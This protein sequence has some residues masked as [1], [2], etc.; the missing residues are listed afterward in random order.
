MAKFR[1]KVAS[2]SRNGVGLVLT[3]LAYRVYILPTLSFIAQLHP[4]PPEWARTEAA[5]LRALVKGPRC[6][7]RPTDLHQLHA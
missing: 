3:A 1:D 2:W 4:P 6:W 7:A 5:A